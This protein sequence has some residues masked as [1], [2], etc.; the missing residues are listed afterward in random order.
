MPHF[1]KMLYDNALLVPVYLHGWLVTGND[2][3]RE[4]ATETLDDMLRE[5]ALDEG[6]FASAED[7][8]TDGVEGLTYTWTE[9]R[10]RPTPL[11]APV[12]AR[13]PD[14]PRRP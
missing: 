8:D 12:R 7:A 6:G 1:E 9:E 13:T 14:H 5:L 3:Y 4:I 2:R 10:Q 11:A